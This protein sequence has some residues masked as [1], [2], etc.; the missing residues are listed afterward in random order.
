VP[1]DQSLLN[2]RLSV[3]ER[4][5]ATLTWIDAGVDGLGAR[6]AIGERHRRMLSV[7]RRPGRAW[8]PSSGVRIRSA[9]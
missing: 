2:G 4:T 7:G 9:R 5:R 3:D 6:F 1:A 8:A